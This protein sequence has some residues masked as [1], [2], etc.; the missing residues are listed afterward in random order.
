MAQYIIIMAK[1]WLFKERLAAISIW[2]QLHQME[3]D[4]IGMFLPAFLFRIFHKE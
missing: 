4:I 1:E 2:R 3:V